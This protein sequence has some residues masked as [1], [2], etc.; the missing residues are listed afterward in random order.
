ME[1]LVF[2]EELW[3]NDGVVAELDGIADDNCVERAGEYFVALVMLE[4]WAHVK[5]LLAAEVPGA[6]SGCFGVDE[7]AAA[8]W[9]HWRGIKVVGTKEMFPGGESVVPGSNPARGYSKQL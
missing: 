8:G 9:A 1:Q 7:D 3:H 4:C 2:K 5:L 6:A